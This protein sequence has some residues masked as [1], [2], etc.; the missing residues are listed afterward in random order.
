MKDG[1]VS[2]TII[3]KLLLTSA[4]ITSVSKTVVA[5]LIDPTR[6]GN[7]AMSGQIVDAAQQAPDSIV[8]QAIY[9]RPDKPSALISGNRYVVNDLLAEYTIKEISSDKVMLVGPDGEKE[10]RLNSTQ[11]KFYDDSANTMSEVKE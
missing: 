11:V 6:P 3:I 10:L 5:E 1:L 8:L 7:F 9:F 4:L 2:K